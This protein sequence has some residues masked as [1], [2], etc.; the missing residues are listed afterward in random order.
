MCL[1][2]LSGMTGL[3]VFVT[4]LE[5]WM[6]LR[7]VAVVGT[8][9]PQIINDDTRGTDA[10]D[11][12]VWAE[13][14]FILLAGDIPTS[15]TLDF[16]V[17]ES[18]AADFL[19]D[20]TDITGKSIVQLGASDDN[21]QVVINLVVAECSKRYVRGFVTSSPHNNQLAVLALGWK[22]NG[23]DTVATDDLASV[24]QIVA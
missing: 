3:S 14:Q 13:M 19:S 17:Q 4:M 10:I 23:C 7:C 2:A 6:S 8:I 9:D 20:V 5:A 18:D 21:K 12:Q 1:T 11:T 24:A 15:G 22:P 16:K